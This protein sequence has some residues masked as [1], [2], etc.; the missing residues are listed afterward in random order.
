MA[1]IVQDPLNP[2]ETANSYQSLADYRARAAIIGVTLPDDNT[3]AE[4]K[5]LIG[6]QYVDNKDFVG[7]TVIAFQ[8]TE[9]PRSN[10][11]EYKGDKEYVYSDEVIPQQVID[12][13]LYVANED[14]VYV[15][16]TS[17]E[18][19]KTAKVDVISTE[20]FDD[21]SQVTGFKRVTRADSLLSRFVSKAP[22]FFYVV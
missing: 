9:W 20:Y 12:A 1:L 17:G 3:K 10:I 7:E 14:N 2:T 4:Q 8:G 18:R 13:V 6:Q 22:N 15:T 21:G 19:I 11:V 5:I 16:Q